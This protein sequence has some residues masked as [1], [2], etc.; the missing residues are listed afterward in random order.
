MPYH[1][2]CYKLLQKVTMNKRGKILVGFSIIVLL[3]LTGLFFLSS[4]FV[5]AETLSTYGISVEKTGESMPK[6]E[7]NTPSS[8]GGG[9]GG[10]SV[11][12]IY[13]IYNV[14]NAIKEKGKNE[15]EDKEEDNIKTSSDG[16]VG[17]TGGVI[18]I[19]GQLLSGSQIVFIVVV[20]CGTFII[21]ILVKYRIKKK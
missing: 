18:G 19:G 5:M 13:N 16:N 1:L 17:I 12:N 10:S 8:S 11:T 6:S 15:E 2:Q 21:F 4:S 14:T 7:S 9:G 3:V 20:L